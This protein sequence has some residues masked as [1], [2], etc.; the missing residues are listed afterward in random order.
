MMR[1]TGGFGRGCNFHQV[2]PLLPGDRQR[3]LRR[4]DAQLLPGVVDDP[5]L[6]P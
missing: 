2:E 6:G 3:L 5:H 4:H 1:H